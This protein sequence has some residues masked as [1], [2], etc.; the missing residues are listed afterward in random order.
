MKR[1][2]PLLRLNA[3]LVFAFL[4]LPIL[5]LVLFSFSASR[6]SLVWGGFT[7]QWYARLSSNT[8][9]IE[10]LLNS[11][12]VAASTTLLSTLMGTLAA[13][14]L[15]QPRRF[16]RALW[17]SC[18]YLPVVMPELV[19]GLALLMLFVVVAKLPLGL[20][21]IT[22]AHTVFGIAYVTLVVRTR[23]AGLDPHLAEAAR[24]LGASEWKIFYR[25][26]LPMIWPGILGGA[27]LAFTLS[28]DDFVIAFFVTGPGASTLP[29]EIY[30]MV[31]RGVTPEINAIATLIL[32]VSIAL[33][34]LSQ[35]LQRYV[36]G[37]SP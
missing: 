10:A 4:Y 23:L 1:L 31:K 2:N 7:L 21:T 35:R 32:T 5:V 9:L 12:A 37:G 13:L 22:L 24:D 26:T 30:A 8:R 20:L 25:I 34:A 11:L 14:A 17:V 18:F 29:I 28:F 19:Q 15:E 16:G 36:S 3:W 6:Y 33:I 27:L